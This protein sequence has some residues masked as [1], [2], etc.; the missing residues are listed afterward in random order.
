MRSCF[1]KFM[2]KQTDFVIFR[3]GE[4]RDFACCSVS[5]DVKQNSETSDL[6]ALAC[7]TVK[8]QVF[9]NRQFSGRPG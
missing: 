9:L 6:M 1:H 4:S 2:N 3:F 8:V 7:I 5:D